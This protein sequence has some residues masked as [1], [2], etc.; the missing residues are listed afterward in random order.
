[1]LGPIIKDF[2]GFDSEKMKKEMMKEMTSMVN[3]GV[4]I[5]MEEATPEEM[6]NINGSKWVHRDKGEEAR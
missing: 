6:Q 3:Q 1:M 2:Q 4:E 5:P